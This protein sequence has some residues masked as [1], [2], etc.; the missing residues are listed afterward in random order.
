MVAAA[1]GIGVAVATAAGSI[2]SSNKAS[3]ST[4]NATNAS[5]AEQQAAL[6]Q[7]A[8]LSQPYRDLGSGAI[9]QLQRLLGI[10][11]VDPATGLPPGASFDP[12]RNPS[13]P[14]AAGGSDIEAALRSTPG[15]QFTLNEG[16]NATKNAATASG[17]ALSGN[18]LEALDR[19]STGLADQ[20]YQQTVGNLENVVG[21]GQAA[22]AGQA[23][24]IGN[25]ANNTSNL[26]MNQGNTLAAI[27]ANEIAGITK[28]IG[29]GINQR[30]TL[31][32]FN[33]GGGGEGSPYWGVNPGVS[34]PFDSGGG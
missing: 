19:Y 15:Y 32:A 14:G 7:Q 5:I 34:V 28:G 6:E 22:A 21:L 30:A 3:S 11:G 24:N 29:N 12:T 9:P 4:Q 20:T 18:T 1:V 13:R 27:Q 17:M 25:A 16:L 26:I 8:K 10:G 33:S 31:N 23:A 2:Y